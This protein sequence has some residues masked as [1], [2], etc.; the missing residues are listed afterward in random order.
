M[1]LGIVRLFSSVGKEGDVARG[2]SAKVIEMERLGWRGLGVV[3][4]G[5]MI[6]AALEA[7]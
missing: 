1:I 7:E 2:V 3:G 6:Q 4:V 5:G